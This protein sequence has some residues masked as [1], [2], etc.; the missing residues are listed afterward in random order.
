MIINHLHFNFFL[1]VKVENILA[2]SKA[3][4]VPHVVN[5]QESTE[6]F[7]NRLSGQL[8]LLNTNNLEVGI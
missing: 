2:L 3:P 8:T 7:L 5:K 1:P 6:A 4:I